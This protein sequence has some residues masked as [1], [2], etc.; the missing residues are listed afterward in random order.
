M[1]TFPDVDEIHPDEFVT[2]KVYVPS[3]KPE[4][5]LFVPDPG[6]VIP[7]GARVRVHVPLEGKPL[8]STPPVET[9]QVGVVITPITGAVGVAG[10][11]LITTADEGPDMQPTAL[12]TVKV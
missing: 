1:T 6:V 9:V 8:K 3:I 4:I 5:V 12:V 2:V 11:A 10:C 7:P